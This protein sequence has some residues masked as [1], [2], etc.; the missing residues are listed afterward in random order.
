MAF[1]EKETGEM[2]Q[3]LA[4]ISYTHDAM[5]DLIIAEPAV[6]QGDLAK[7]FGY[8]Q[9]WVSTVKNSDAFQARLAE[10]RGELIDPAIVASID[11]KFRALADSSLS[12]LIERVNGPLK[13]T[14]DFLIQTAK[15]SAGALGY[16]AKPVGGAQT[17]NIAL[18]V[19]V[20]PKIQ[21]S[22]DWAAAHAPVIQRVS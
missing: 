12:M 8:T 2:V 20:P 5:I 11:E 17:T 22:S 3:S 15:L 19:Q 9:S 14:D 13:V 16:G 21:S 6:S 1:L 4:K 7:F 18:V 10:R